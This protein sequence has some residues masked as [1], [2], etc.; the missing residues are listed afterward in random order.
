MIELMRPHA[1][2]PLGFKVAGGIDK[3]YSG[4]TFDADG[5]YVLALEKRSVFL[6]SNLAE[7]TA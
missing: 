6:L 2:A 1:K 7:L 4:A 3:P 5:I